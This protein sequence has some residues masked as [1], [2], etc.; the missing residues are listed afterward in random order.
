MKPRL[1][2]EEYI[3]LGKELKFMR[4]IYWR[5]F[6]KTTGN[7][8]KR[9]RTINYL[10]KLDKDLTGLYYQVEADFLKDYPDEYGKG[11]F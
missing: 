3:K 8:P 10:L 2:K 11:T 4:G 9:S 1:S 7:F 6:R 5:V